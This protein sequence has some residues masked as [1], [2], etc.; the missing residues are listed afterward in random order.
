MAAGD[1]IKILRFSFPFLVS[2]SIK[3][4]RQRIV[5]IFHGLSYK[6]GPSP[7]NIVI[8]GGSFAGIF[9]AKRLCDSLPSGY[10]IIL[11]EKN[12]HFHFPFV[13]PRF[14]VV[15]GHE[16]KAFIP[17]DEIL[18]S[19][20]KG[21]PEGIFERRCDA[22][23]EVTS[24]SVRLASGE[25]IS[26]EFLAVA[27]GTS[28]PRP[29][30]LVSPDK[31][32][33]CDELRD[34]QEQVRTAESIAVV[35][36]GAV[37][38]ELVTDIKSWYPEKDVTLVHSRDRLLHGYGP[39]LH[40]RVMEEMRKLDIKVKLG[41]RPR[42]I[43]DNDEKAGKN[44][45]LVFPDGQADKFGLVIPCTGQ[46]PNT[47][48]MRS[49]MSKCISTETARILVAPSLQIK[50]NESTVD[51]MFALGDVA[52]SGGPRMARAAELQ[53][54]IVASNIVS[55]IKSGKASNTYRPITAVEGAIKLTLGKSAIALYSEDDS[56]DNALI[57][58]KGGHEDGDIRR[59]W[60]LLGAKYDKEVAAREQ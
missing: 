14:S 28:S 33:A 50:S 59:C 19:G 36:G 55:L 10:K 6:P 52:E 7:K 37:G 21:V 9:L 48:F 47:E 3:R 24:D 16:A 11:I 22:V 5:A 41:Q 12:T 20:R 30:K 51:K 4:L 1:V 60:N 17:Y 26:F 31:H 44:A 58:V 56:G 46:A 25:A 57:S 8:I 39:R 23:V 2:Y 43:D 27:T 13:F 38:V 34:T 32:G 49:T 40:E 53:S 29:S 42:I 35:G 45:T 18:Y 54:Y 15:G